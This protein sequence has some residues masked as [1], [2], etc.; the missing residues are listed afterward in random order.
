[1][2]TKLINTWARVRGFKFL[3]DSFENNFFGGLI[4]SLLIKQLTQTTH[5]LDQFSTPAFLCFPKTLIPRWDLNLRS[6]FLFTFQI[7]PSRPR[8]HLVFPAIGYGWQQ[9]DQMSLWKN[10]PKCSHFLLKLILKFYSG[11]R[12]PQIWVTYSV[13]FEKMRPSHQFPNRRKLRWCGHPG[14]PINKI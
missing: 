8:C 11:K 13:I 7:F 12:C 14:W 2:I 9:G 10:H 4:P 6:P 5:V 3:L 1:M